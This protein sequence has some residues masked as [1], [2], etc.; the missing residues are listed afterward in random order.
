MTKSQTRKSQSLSPARLKESERELDINNIEIEDDM[1]LDALEVIKNKLMGKM[2]L[3]DKLEPVVPEDME[4]GE[5]SDSGDEEPKDKSEANP[6]KKIEVNL[7]EKSKQSPKEKL[8]PK[9]EESVVNVKDLRDRLKE[10]ERNRDTTKEKA[11][12]PVKK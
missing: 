2:G 11:L 9:P 8:K 3:D 6:K 5:V 12:S 1:S 4:E 10:V 7:K